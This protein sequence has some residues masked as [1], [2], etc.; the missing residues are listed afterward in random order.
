MKERD[1]GTTLSVASAR[2]GMC[3]QTGAKYTR[4]AKLPS[5]LKAPRTWLTR[6]NPFEI[7]WKEVEQ[8]LA[9]TPDLQAKTIFEVL[10]ERNPDRYEPGQL[11]TL[12]R[13]IRR[14]HALQGD[15]RQCEVFFP[16][17][18]IAG[19]AMQGDFTHTGE[20]TLTL[21]GVQYKPL[22]FHVVLPFSGWEWAT[23]CLSESILAVRAGVQDAVFRLGKIT[24]WFQTDN[25]TGATH[26]VGDGTRQFNQEYVDLMD[27][28]GMKPRTIAVGEKEQNGTIEAYN[29]A[30]KRLLNQ[31]LLVRG[32]RD[33]ASEADF[34]T[35]LHG[36]LERANRARRTKLG[37]ELAAM[38][39][40]AASRAPEF[41][42]VMVPV[43]TYSTINVRSNIYSVPPRLRHHDV[44]VRIYEQHIEVRYADTC[45]LVA[46]RQ[47]GTSRHAIDYR[48]VIWSLVRKP[49]AFARYRY[50]EDLMISPVFRRAYEA[51]HASEPGTKGDA[52][53]LRLLLLAAS[54]L[55]S[56][57]EAALVLLME[58]GTLPTADAVK[59]L[60]A[61]QQRPVVPELPILNVN[62]EDYDR[63]IMGALS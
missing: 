7:D 46:P 49:G 57:V 32:S 47:T 1:K 3:R 30:F 33:F 19:E 61:P 13:H 11:R 9:H 21:A 54:T 41:T 25:S 27:H 45:V 48:H 42:E 4:R 35:W 50:R 31:W 14:W 55:Q 36:M 62:L 37:I 39:P 18:H 51:L 12:Q 16:Q 26:R 8:M 56:D 63:L 28:L 2:A 58:Q 34:V 22:L 15:D 59:D 40:L 10:L 29:G 23:P 52:A 20:L 24:A 53:Y 43:S 38:R 17:R 44:K 5:E 60:I 6:G